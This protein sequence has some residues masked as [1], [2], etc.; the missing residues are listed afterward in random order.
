[1]KRF[2]IK[3]VAYI[4]IAFFLAVFC[5]CN[6]ISAQGVEEYSYDNFIYGETPTEGAVRQNTQNSVNAGQITQNEGAQVS[7]NVQP[8]KKESS[9]TISGKPVSG[10]IAP[11]VVEGMNWILYGISSALAWALGWLGKAIDVVVA[12]TQGLDGHKEILKQLKVTWVILRDTFDVFFIFILLYISIQ[13]I[14]KGAAANAKKM[15]ASVVMAALLINFSFMITSVAIDAG[16]IFTLAIYNKG[17]TVTKNNGTV[18]S[19]I[20]DSL[21]IQSLE[22][23]TEKKAGSTKPALSKASLGLTVLLIFKIILISFVLWAFS[24]ILALLV[25]RTVVLF[26]LLALSPIGFVGNVIPKM[27]EYSKKWGDALINQTLVGPVFAFLLT[28]VLALIGSFE[29]SN[30]ADVLGTKVGGGETNTEALVGLVFNLAIVIGFLIATVNITKKLSGEIGAFATG[31]GAKMLGGVAGLA[32]GGVGGFALRNTLGRGAAALAN[33]EKFKG[34]AANSAVGRLALRG[35]NNVSK[36]TFDARNTGLAKTVNKKLGVDLGKGGGKDGFKGQA[37]RAT[38]SSVEMAKLLETD[39]GSKGGKAVLEENL[40]AARDVKQKENS[41]A[42][43][44]DSQAIIAMKAEKNALATKNAEIEAKTK[45]NN[46]KKQGSISAKDWKK[47]Q[48]KIKEN[49]KAM[50]A[51]K[52]ANMNKI[53]EKEREIAAREQARKQKI[54]KIGTD[55]L[56]A[57]EKDRVSKETKTANQTIYAKG[58]E[59]SFIARARGGAKGRRANADKIRKTVIGGKTANDLIVEQ[60]KKE[61]AEKDKAAA[62]MNSAPTTPTV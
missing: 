4:S 11:G 29:F 31:L 49:N 23:I 9:F 44:V 12:F 40:R 48:V 33:S 14:I 45:Q 62:D 21:D 16:N 59:N 37:D 28:V 50:E 34:A 27:G 60:M 22:D 5:L 2:F 17:A 20:M 3:S 36:N 61:Q 58:Q 35:V 41:N 24:K 39:L 25:A 43:N 19:Q 7:P 55:M 1:M 10:L 52:I 56:S 54:D 30:I 42:I 6:V 32:I 18:T 57:E 8:P 13:T 51:E 53:A 38:A 26:L 46:D 15:L 47:E